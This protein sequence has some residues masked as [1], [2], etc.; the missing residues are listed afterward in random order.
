MPHYRP[1]PWIAAARTVG[2]VSMAA[3]AW[4]AAAPPAAAQQ[5]GG[6]AP[7]VAIYEPPAVDEQPR[8]L[9]LAILRQM[10]RWYPPALLADGV[11]GAVFLRF[12]ILTD[13]SV[14]SVSAL[15]ATDA[16]FV[17]PAKTIARRFAYTPAKVGGRPVT[18]WHTFDLRFLPT[19]RT[20]YDPG[21]R[22]PVLQNEDEIHRLT[23][24]QYPPAL[25]AGRVGG[26][27]LVRFRVLTDGRVDSAS[28]LPLQST[29][30][31]L[32]EPAVAVAR[33]LAF[34]PA[35]VG[36]CPVE[37]WHSFNF[38]FDPRDGVGR[39]DVGRVAAPP[40]PP[41]EGC[42]PSAAMEQPRLL[43]ADRVARRMAAVYPSALADSGIV[44]EVHLRFRVL[45]NGRV[46]PESVSAVQASNQ[47]FAEAAI[48]L[49]E[50]MR[51]RPARVGGRPVVA[52]AVL[53][54]H[55]QLPPRPAVSPD[56]SGRGGARP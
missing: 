1:R 41:A 17:E 36:G 42:V 50:E 25:R 35:L 54:F 14:D 10:T 34:R 11:S 9:N 37:Y 8:L 26:A 27:V 6:T 45:L 24:A 44:G 5:T 15:Q 47:A 28:V 51:F 38:L 31:A 32:V 21:D 48:R 52:W 33:Q 43:N 4:L 19:P 46:D 23:T 53:P 3:G 12:R 13:G 16:A 20:A 40:P 7:P 56:S 22:M 29:H 30:A 2:L 55:F 39:A 18:V 49:V